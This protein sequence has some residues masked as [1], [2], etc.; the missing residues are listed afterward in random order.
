LTEKGS[1][2]KDIIHSPSNDI[3][4]L[5]REKVLQKKGEYVSSMCFEFDR[6]FTPDTTQSEVYAE[7]EELVLGSLEGFKTCMIA[8]GQSGS[9][10]TYNMIGEFNISLGDGFGED[11]MPTVELKHLGIHLLAARQLFDASN[12]R[13]SV[14]EDSFQLSILEVIDEKL[15]DL[16]AGTDVAESSGVVNDIDGKVRKDVESRRNS[17]ASSDSRMKLEIKSNHEGDTIVQGQVSVP[18][19]SF[20]D[21]LNVWKQSLALRARRMKNDGSTLELC[22]SNRHLI[23]TIEILS[24][25]LTTGIGTFGKLQCVDLAA[26]DVIPK[27]ESNS[28]RSKRTSMDD[29][30]ASLGDNTEWR[31]VHKSISTFAE[32][33]DARV[34]FSRSPPYRNSTLTHVL[35]DALEA[36]TKTMFL[37]CVKSDPKDIQ[38]AANSLR[39]ASKVKKV[40]LGKATK[41]FI[42]IA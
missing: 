25:N 1:V 4:V 26:S 41:R 36:D 28:S 11:A 34:N 6:V 29:V 37:V 23:A 16:V 27:R 2:K 17:N 38:D 8:Y 13:K 32:V 39:L 24:T 10:K 19:E 18:V 3:L 21:V 9:G 7:M 5:H 33:I 42:T 20:N 31:F 15:I 12:E 22:D 30:L 35:R 14:F 40:V